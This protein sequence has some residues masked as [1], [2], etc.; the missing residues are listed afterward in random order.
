MKK[1]LLALILSL[2]PVV[3]N[4][5]DHF[6]DRNHT[7]R[8]QLFATQTECDQAMHLGSNCSQWITLS[9]DG[10][11][12]MIVTDIVNV[13]EYKIVGNEVKVTLHPG[14]IEPE[15]IYATTDGFQ[16]LTLQTNGTVWKLD[17]AN[18]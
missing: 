9:T 14:E 10:K 16:T 8:H 2:L 18:D 17:P 4:A 7:Y 6:T 3:S 12:L 15:Q 11:A 1:L 5:E 13:G